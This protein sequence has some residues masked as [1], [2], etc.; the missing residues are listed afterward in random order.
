MLYSL[1]AA[2][3]LFKNYYNETFSHTVHGDMEFIFVVKLN[4]IQLILK[5][6]F[7]QFPFESKTK[8]EIENEIR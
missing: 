4:E 5:Y 7:L 1:I 2:L 6:N 8:G 3:F